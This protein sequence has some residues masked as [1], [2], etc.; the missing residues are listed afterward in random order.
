MTLIRHPTRR[1]ID[2]FFPVSSEPSPLTQTTANPPS[3]QV[4]HP[5]PKPAIARPMSEPL[6][7]T[8]PSALRASSLSGASDPIASR[9]PTFLSTSRTPSPPPSPQSMSIPP[10]PAPAADKFSL[11]YPQALDPLPPTANGTT[12]RHA[13]PMLTPLPLPPPILR[14]ST[15]PPPCLNPPNPTLHTNFS[16]LPSPNPN[17][18]INDSIPTRTSSTSRRPI[19]RAALAPA[20][21]PEAISPETL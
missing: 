9:G 7:R 20:P 21:A 13:L 5:H 1:L 15:R 17:G 3:P 16:P 14:P 8:R 11:P 18:Y 19:L 12:T 6:E 10:F 4:S 2:Q